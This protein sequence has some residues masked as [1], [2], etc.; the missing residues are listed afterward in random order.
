MA[1][2]VPMADLADFLA[3]SIYSSDK[4]SDENYI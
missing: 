1:N 3:N 2:F 4:T